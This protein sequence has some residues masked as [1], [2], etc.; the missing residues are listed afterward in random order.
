[1]F[2]LASVV[3][4]DAGLAGSD[5]GGAQFVLLVVGA[6]LLGWYAVR[7]HRSVPWPVFAV[8]C[9]AALPALGFAMGAASSGEEAEGAVAGL[10]V[11]VGV[12]LLG[13]AF[14]GRAPSPVGASAPGHERE[15]LGV[16]RDRGG[17]VTVSEVA[18]HSSLSLDQARAVLD[19]LAGRGHCERVA[20][21]G[22]PVRYRFPDFLPG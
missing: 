11:G 4:L 7:L 13:L 19:H 16:A 14:R 1:M 6:L 17:E 9:V 21:P 12:A 22:G 20:P 8:A 3:T 2:V 18:L 15:V 10:V 5:T